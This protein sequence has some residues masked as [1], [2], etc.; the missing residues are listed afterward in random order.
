MQVGDLHANLARAID[1]DI[2]L[3]AVVHPSFRQ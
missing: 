3:I 1:Y 2:R